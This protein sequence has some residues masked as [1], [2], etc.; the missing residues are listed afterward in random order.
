MKHTLLSIIAL[1]LTIAATGQT[2]KITTGSGTKTYEA[3][4]VTAS[5]PA[6]FT[7]GSMLTVGNDVFTIS[8]ITGMEVVSSQASGVEANTVEIYPATSRQK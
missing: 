5:S 6:T 3:S 7:G 1:V 2:L 4:Q 8:D